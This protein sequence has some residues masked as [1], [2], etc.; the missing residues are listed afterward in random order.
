MLILA[1][2][3]SNLIGYIFFDI[4]P[5]DASHFVAI[6]IYYWIVNLNSCSGPSGCVFKKK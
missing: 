5:N 6:Q 2:Q 1:F 4:L 3:N